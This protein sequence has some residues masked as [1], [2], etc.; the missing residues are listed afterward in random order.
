MGDLQVTPVPVDTRTARMDL[1]FSLAECFT[2][3]GEPAGIS[4]EVEF[5]T[6]VFDAASIEALIGAVRAGVGGDDRRSDTAVVVGGCAGCGEHARLDEVGNR[7]VLTRPAAASVSVPVLFA[8]QVART[9]EAVALTFEGRS[10]TY[11]ELDEASNRLAHLLV[12]QGAGPGQCVALLFSRSAEAIVAIL[13]VLKTGAAYLPV[14]PA[15]PAA[16]IGFMLGDAAPIAA[17]TTTGLADRLDGHDLLVIDVDDPRIDTYPC[18]ALPAPAADDIAYL[19]YTSGTTGVPKGV[20]IAHQ[21]V[22]RLLESLHAGLPRGPGQVWSQWHSYSF[23]VSVWEIFGA[24]LHGGRL[25]VVPESVAASPADL[26]ALLVAEQVSVLGQTP[27]AVGMLSPQGLD[28]TALMVAGEACPIEVVDR[29]APGRVMINAYGPTEATVYAAMSAPLTS[30]SG[31]VPIG[32]PV[33]GAGLF[34]LDKFLRPVPAGCGRVSCMWP[35]P[36]WGMGMWAGRSLT[37]SRFVACPFGGPGARMYRTG[38][39]VCWG[40]DG[41][42]AY[43]GRADEQV[44]IRGYRIEL[45]EIQT[46]L[47]DLDGVA[48]RRWWLPGRTVPVTSVWWVMSP[49]RDR[50]GRSGRGAYRAG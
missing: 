15:L 5:R 36:G 27:S 9:P 3:T 28:S 23:D 40:A 16:R 17:I 7:A 30:G 21:N 1:T 13:A 24:L 47:A 26:H 37:G 8:A 14:D 18:T 50:G 33:P 19:I 42:L 35:V 34:V 39:L 12:A 46:A 43:L 11:R 45:G 38:D 4:G 2:E 41:Q 29:W 44:K 31:V 22:T 32:A 25:V 20:A 10:L 49:S 6:D 48:I